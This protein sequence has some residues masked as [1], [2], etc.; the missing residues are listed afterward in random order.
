MSFDA[1]RLLE[2]LPELYRVRDAEQGGPLRDLL[3]VVADQLTILEDDLDQLYD[4]QFVETCAAWVLPYIGDLVGVRALPSATPGRLT[5]RAEVANTIAYRRRKGTAAVLEDLARDVTSY[6]ARALEFFQ[7]LA[8]TQFL[9]HRRPGNRSF[10]SVRDAARLEDLGGAFE[11]LPGKQDLTHNVEVRGVAHDGGRYNIPNVGI[12]LWRLLA[13]PLTAAPAVSDASNPLRHFRFHPLGVDAPL[14]NLPVPER[15]MAALARPA[16]VPGPI[17]RR[18]LDASLRGGAHTDPLYGRSLALAF[19]SGVAAA[20]LAVEP[21]SSIIACD[22]SDDATHGPWARTPRE[23]G[24]PANAGRLLFAI[25]PVLGRIKASQDLNRQLLVSAHHAFAADIGGGEYER[26]SSF[27]VSGATP[28]SV[29]G[30]ASIQNA[31]NALGS[32]G[33]IVELTDNHRYAA[34]LNVPAHPSVEL[35]AANKRRATLV[36]SADLAVG[37]APTSAVTLNGLLIGGAPVRA[38][39]GLRLLRLRHLTLVPTAGMPSLIITSPDVL[40]EID[41]CILGAIRA[42]PDATV[43]ITNSIVDASSES[44]PAFA[45]A[46][47]TGE[48]A[49]LVVENSTIIGRVN[50]AEL[51]LAS[52]TIFMGR[53]VARRRQLGCLRF[54][55]VPLDSEVPRRFRCQPTGAADEHRVRPVFAS[56]RYGA[57]T[58]GLL[59]GTC[60]IEIRRGADDESELGAFHDLYHP[61]REDHLRARLGEYLRFGL[62]VGIFYAT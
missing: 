18:R 45:D 2:L 42:H 36:L 57:A 20:P 46:A 30:G 27:E 53:V 61:Q 44:E 49:R 1:K 33:G 48:G 58:Y 59:A 38:A 8:T 40:V 21:A 35:R 62:E 15:E 34:N 37:G 12:F 11:Q 41:S 23:F 54:C 29:S 32:T 43:R 6:P 50:T 39:G 3:G 55:Y 16:S 13:Q 14:V 10:V 28:R 7:I 31:L 9:N 52:N 24:D 47:G 25:D 56:T 22:L 51:E 19:A 17:S 60:P 26:T 5:P 4:D